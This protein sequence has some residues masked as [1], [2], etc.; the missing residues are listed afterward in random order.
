VRIRSIR[1]TFGK[2]SVN[3][4]TTA[5]KLHLQTAGTRGELKGRQRGF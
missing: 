2:V 1:I 4:S 5:S 3:A